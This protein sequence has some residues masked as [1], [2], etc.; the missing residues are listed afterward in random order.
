MLTAG[1]IVSII[2]FIATFIDFCRTPTWKFAL[3]MLVSLAMFAA[4]F[5]ARVAVYGASC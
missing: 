3:P 2:M 4:F 1:A 5:G